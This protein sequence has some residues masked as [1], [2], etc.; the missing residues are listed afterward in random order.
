MM[1][2]LLRYKLF[3]SMYW[4]TASSTQNLMEFPLFTAFRI[5]VEL[6]SN[7]ILSVTTWIFFLYFCN[8][9]WY[10]MHFHGLLLCLALTRM[11]KFLTTYSISLLGQGFRQTASKRSPPMTAKIL[12]LRTS[13]LMT[14]KSWGN[15]LYLRLNT[16]GKKL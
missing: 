5:S 10:F 3:S 16:D 6:S 2:Y 14:L 1:R 11:L 12:N 4:I 8:I 7:G 13:L 9:G 15:Y